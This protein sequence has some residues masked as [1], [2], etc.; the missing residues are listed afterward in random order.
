[1]TNTVGTASNLDIRPVT[2]EGW[3]MG[4]VEW[5]DE[6]LMPDVELGKRLGYAEPRM[7][8][9]LIKS[10]LTDLGGICHRSTAERY[11]IKPGQWH[12]KPTD[13]YH[14][15]ESQALFV[16]AKS[17]TAPATDLLKEMIRVY[18][19]ARR[20]QLHDQLSE[21]TVRAI[22]AECAASLAT[23]EQVAA[24]AA[25]V[26]ECAHSVER[27]RKEMF[28]AREEN[29]R[30]AKMFANDLELVRS[31]SS[32]PERFQE[33][34]ILRGSPVDHAAMQKHI[35]AVALICKRSFSAIAGE[36]N[37]ALGVPGYTLLRVSLWEK[38]HLVLDEIQSGKRP[39]L[40]KG[41][42]CST[43]S[44]EVDDCQPWLPFD[45]NPKYQ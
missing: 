32:N 37:K 6:P 20:G 10:H 17:A 15:T 33:Y 31:A 5:S 41:T 12:S 23:K 9:K 21:N 11:E 24:I 16:A 38:A 4:F 35:R 42:R 29:N 39:L 8:R 30:R 7:I 1:M 26:V 28:E 45:R 44:V 36:L 14:L 3:T 27:A 19:L 18:M 13:E 2:I 43:R 40:P 34:R 25:D 22:F